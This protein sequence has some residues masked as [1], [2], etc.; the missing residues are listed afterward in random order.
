[1]LA[2]GEVP[3]LLGAW[4]LGL[5]GTGGLASLLAV[6]AG[7]VALAAGLGLEYLVDRL[8]DGWRQACLTARTKRFARKLGLALAGSGSSCSGS[9]SS[10]RAR[11]WWAG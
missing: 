8:V 10:G 9:W 3:G 7:V 2:A 4:W 6:L 11:S 5:T 1:M